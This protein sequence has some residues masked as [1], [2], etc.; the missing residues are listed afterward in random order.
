MLAFS[1]NACCFSSDCKNET[2]S[3]LIRNFAHGFSSWAPLS[4]TLKAYPSPSI[5]QMREKHGEETCK[6]MKRWIDMFQDMTYGEITTTRGKI[7][8][9]SW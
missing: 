8:G 3:R 4:A 6:F 7:M 1:W 2:G 5:Y 9:K